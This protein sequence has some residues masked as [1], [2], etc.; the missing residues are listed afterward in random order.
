MSQHQARCKSGVGPPQSKDAPLASRVLE[1]ESTT[2][3]YNC[4]KKVSQKFYATVRL[5]CCAFSWP[6]PLPA[7]RGESGR[8][9]GLRSANPGCA[10]RRRA[11]ATLWRAA[12]A[13][14]SAEAKAA[15]SP[16]AG[17]RRILGKAP[18]ALR[19]HWNHEPDWTHPSPCPLSAR[20]GEGG[21]RLGEG[22]SLQAAI[23]AANMLKIVVLL[24]GED[25]GFW[26]LKIVCTSKP[27]FFLS[28]NRLRPV[29]SRCVDLTVPRPGAAGIEEA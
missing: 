25:G 24:M 28:A 7:R 22:R 2:F 13:G 10:G 15:T 3:C 20:R 8:R 18:S 16:Q 17:D 5:T 27:A 1:N 26:C 29:M 4:N 14:G 12:E 6:T 9:P 19:M 21:R 23:L 11:E